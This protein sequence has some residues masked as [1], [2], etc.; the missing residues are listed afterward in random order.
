MAS[1]FTREGEVIGCDGKKLYSVHGFSVYNLDGNN[2]PVGNGSVGYVVDDVA[3]KSTIE[4]IPPVLGKVRW[5]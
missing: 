2:R 1:E 5:L 4:S 3:Y